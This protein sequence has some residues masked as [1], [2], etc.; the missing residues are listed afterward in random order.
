MQVYD[1][2]VQTVMVPKG[3]KTLESGQKREIRVPVRI[4]LVCM[5]DDVKVTYN[6]KFQKYAVTHKDKPVTFRNGRP[7]GEME[8]GTRFGGMTRAEFKRQHGAAFVKLVD[9]AF[10]PLIMG[11]S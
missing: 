1:A 9:D 4:G 5:V 11:L 8:K 6:F 3:V 2:K 10:Y 7:T